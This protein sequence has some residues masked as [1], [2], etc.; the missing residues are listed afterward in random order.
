MTKKVKK[1]IEQYIN[2][3]KKDNLPINEVILFGSQAKD[4]AHEWSDI[5]ICV[6]SPKFKDSFKALHYLLKKSYEVEDNI[7]EPHP[8]NP[9]DFSNNNDPLVWEI[10]QTGKVIYKKQ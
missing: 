6:I 3:L 8:F 7:I 4:Q 9:K 2:I 5:D 10:K 1:S